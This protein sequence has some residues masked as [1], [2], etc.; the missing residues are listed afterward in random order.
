MIFEPYGMGEAAPGQ[1]QLCL[2][3]SGHDYFVSLSAWPDFVFI[4]FKV[5]R[6]CRNRG[7]D[8]L[9]GSERWDSLK[10]RQD[11]ERV[12]VAKF[13]AEMRSDI[14]GDRHKRGCG[15]GQQTFGGELL[16]PFF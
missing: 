14:T 2:N 6:V 9:G 3:R 11:L 8:R 5:V 16:A 1:R 12:D 4:L 7:K 15:S 10:H 13:N